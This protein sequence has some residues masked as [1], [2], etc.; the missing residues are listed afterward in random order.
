MRG[1]LHSW[2]LRPT[3]LGAAV[4]ALAT[5]WFGL[6]SAQAGC[7]STGGCPEAAVERTELC[8]EEMAQIFELA[9]Q[10]Q[11][12]SDAPSYPTLGVGNPATTSE[13]AT[14]PC[15]LLKAIGYTESA[16]TQFCADCGSIGPTIISFD[17]GYGVTQVTS[18][19]S[20]GS[21]GSVSFS[22]YRVASE[23]AYNIG[24][25]AAILAVKWATVPYIGDNQPS[26]VEHWYYAVWG[27]NGF[28]YV[29]NPNNPSYPSTRPPY[30]SPSGL[31][32][33]SYPY[34][35][36]VWGFSA[37][38]PSGLYEA[39]DL[40]YPS[41]S[42]IGESP[43]YIPSPSPTHTDLCTGGSVIVD[44]ADPGFQFTSGAT[45]V[46]TTP[47]GGY[48]DSF[49]HQAPYSTSIPYT[50]GQWTPD[51]PTTALY[52]VDVYLPASSSAGSTQAPFDLAFQGGHAVQLVDQSAQSGD[53]LEVFSG[54]AF[55]MVEGERNA[56]FLSN[57]SGESSASRV[58]YDAIRWRYLESVGEGTLGEACTSSAECAGEMVC[59]GQLC[60]D[61]CLV[62]GCD[63][64]S[65]EQE[66]GLCVE[67]E[68]GDD[69]DDIPSD[70]D[71][72]GI[73][74]TVEGSEDNDGDGQPNFIDLDSDGDGIPDSEE[75]SGD[76]DGD[77]VS[78]YL[79]EDSDNDGIPDSEE[80]GDDPENPTDTDG[81]GIPD[82]LDEDSDNDGIPD[83]EEVGGDD[84]DSGTDGGVDDDFL[85]APTDWVDRG[86]ACGMNAS[87]GVSGVDARTRP[88]ASVL[89][90][91]FAVCALHSRRYRWF[92]S[93]GRSV[94]V[95][96]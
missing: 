82:Y 27:Y 40:S 9:G 49:F 53:W 3:L 5:G 76:S 19:M 7:P 69:D 22:P 71:G 23:T 1:P 12:G 15:I 2:I 91:F 43:G 73:P 80:A 94:P 18:G 37:Y 60:A 61:D 31:G 29:N 24:T 81:D 75:G 47:S 70:L 85:G 89:L 38:P 36:I 58:A 55:K 17:C 21:I 65:C 35:E 30:N 84:D 42:A 72:D 83:S 10:A 28:S 56:M 57:L 63:T 32:R 66:T 90:G 93:I 8:N 26:I 46:A 16:W 13:P 50:V 45:G 20:S 34:Q 78:D 4:F 41:S 39:V 87:V 51:I 48:E 79:D 44:D 86:C 67:T 68:G 96:C 95:A 11:L 64:G 59:V 6:R 92:V 52:A 14:L 33:G 25:G 74:D 88:G 54:Q 77:G 62:T